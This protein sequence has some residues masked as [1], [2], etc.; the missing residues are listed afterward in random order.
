M[1]STTFTILHSFD[2]IYTDFY[3]DHVYINIYNIYYVCV[4]VPFLSIPWDVLKVSPN[5][6]GT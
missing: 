2:I 5:I 1:F 4:C 3:E 6:S